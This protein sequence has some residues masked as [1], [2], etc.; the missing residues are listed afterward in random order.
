MRDRALCGL[1][2]VFGYPSSG[3][4][5]CA[6]AHWWLCF[7]LLS[8]DV[9]V[10]QGQSRLIYKLLLHGVLILSSFLRLHGDAGRRAGG[11]SSDQ[12]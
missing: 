12:I 4:V 2:R 1:L 5:F 3:P 9:P 6:S 7:T 8:D 10:G 11:T